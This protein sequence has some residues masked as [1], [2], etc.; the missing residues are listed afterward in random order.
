M[1]EQR[2][3][4]RVKNNGEIEGYYLNTPVDIIDIS[5]AGV[6]LRTEECLPP[7]GL[8]TIKILNFTTIL[9]FKILR[10]NDEDNS[11]VLGFTNKKQLPRMLGILKKIRK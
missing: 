8:I 4:F 10:S 11:Y 3:Y 7:Q 1:D 9:A 2:N 5:A 6:L